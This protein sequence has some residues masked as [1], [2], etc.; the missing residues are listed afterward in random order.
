MKKDIEIKKIEVTEVAMSTK[1]TVYMCC[2]FSS[3]GYYQC[4]VPSEQKNVQENYAVSMSKHF[5]YTVIYKFEIDL[6]NFKNK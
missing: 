2:F 3:N 6:P 1:R 5:E 4:N